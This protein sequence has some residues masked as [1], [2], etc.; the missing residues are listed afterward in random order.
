MTDSLISSSS[1]GLTL[2]GLT[3]DFTTRLKWWTPSTGSESICLHW[4]DQQQKK[5][6]N[7]LKKGRCQ[8]RRIRWRTRN[9]C[10]ELVTPAVSGYSSPF[11]KSATVERAGRFPR[12]AKFHHS[13]T[14]D[15]TWSDTLWQVC[16]LPSRSCMKMRWRASEVSRL[17]WNGITA[18]TTRLNRDEWTLLIEKRVGQ[19]V[20]KSCVVSWQ[21][22]LCYRPAVV[23]SG[24]WS[25]R[26]G[27]VRLR[28]GSTVKSLF[29][30]FF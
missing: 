8:R 29:Y 13:I 20:T 18:Q 4:A 27:N 28:V 9:N 7:F 26:D 16:S 6:F 21:P 30:V 22:L 11:L 10:S 12:V 1:L 3:K 14:L 24:W 2:I 19:T 5:D 15:V 17:R 23:A 25:R